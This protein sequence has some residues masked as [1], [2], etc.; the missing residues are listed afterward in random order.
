M[1]HDQPRGTLKNWKL[2]FDLN[3]LPR[4]EGNIYEDRNK[5]FPNG[6]RVRTSTVLTITEYGHIA[7]TMTES[8]K[9]DPPYER[10]Q[11]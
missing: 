6:R 1:D 3:I 11:S 9:L 5:K 2:K 10:K 7:N 8:F 4:I